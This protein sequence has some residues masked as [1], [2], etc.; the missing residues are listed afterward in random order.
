MITHSL[1]HLNEHIRRVLALNYQQPLW[2]A[3]EIAQ[4]GQSRGHFYLD[5]VQKSE[6][7]DLLA[8]GQAVLWAADYRRIRVALGDAADAVLREGFQVRL[9][10]QVTFHERYGL[11]LQIMELD[12]AHTFGQLELQRRQT[13]Q[14]LRE[15][16]LLDRNRSL[17]LPMVLQRVAVI[18][19]EGAAGFQDFKEHL[20]QNNFGYCFHCHLF[21]SSVQGQNAATELQAALATIVSSKISFD[22]VAIVRGGGARLDLSVFD[23]AALC[24]AIAHM[25][26]PVLVGIGHETDETLLDMVA[27]TSLKT[28]TAV[29]DFLLQHHLLFEGDVLRTAEKL[30]SVSE[31]HLRWSGLKIERDESAIRWNARERLFAAG[32]RLEDMEKQIPMA[33]SQLLR[34]RA[35]FLIQAD[36][37]CNALHP[38]RVLQRGY[39]ITTQNGHVVTSASALNEG[40]QIETHMQ[41]GVFSSIV[42]GTGQL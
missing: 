14:K 38:D 32:R 17:P 10:V 30:R 36:A 13:V 7:G 23:D 8:Q 18:T 33:V 31:Q 11:K 34:S 22:C 29:A 1:Y 21:S 26:L 20:R 16:G 24:H 42:V 27:H 6:E 4:I 40:D 28:P 41:D 39:S 12:P 25:P 2:V 3:A 9:R 35:Q 19:S 5:L 37:L 15:A